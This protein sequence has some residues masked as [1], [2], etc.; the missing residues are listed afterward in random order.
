LEVIRALSKAGISVGLGLAPIIPGL[1]DS[2]IPALVEAAAAAGA[3]S[4][5]RTLLRLPAE[6]EEVFTQALRERLPSHADKVLSLTS[7]MRGGRIRG[8]GFGRRMTGS[9]PLWDLADQLFK[10]SCARSGLNLLEEETGTFS[11][12]TPLN[13]F[14][15]PSAQGDLFDGELA[16]SDG[17]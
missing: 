10:K 15:R 17:T 9:G 4:A 16:G 8:A 13:G 2:Q 5:F 1:N 7:Q 6:L 3:R 11:I 14:R 12:P